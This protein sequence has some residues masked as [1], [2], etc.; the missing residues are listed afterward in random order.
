MGKGTQERKKKRA[1]R[2]KTHEAAGAREV[3]HDSCN[4][5]MRRDDWLT[6]AKLSPTDDEDGDGVGSSCGA[7]V[8][9]PLLDAPSSRWAW[10]PVVGAMCPLVERGC[11]LGVAAEGGKK[12]VRIDRLDVLA[13][14]AG[15]AF[16][17]PHCLLQPSHSARSEGVAAVRGTAR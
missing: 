6:W 12:K 7:D 10:D 8:S 2:E 14:R 13:R 15:P 11:L 16:S 3:V 17:R 4:G 1:A 5:R 9:N